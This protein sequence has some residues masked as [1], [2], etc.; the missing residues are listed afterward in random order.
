MR[1][2]DREKRKIPAALRFDAKFVSLTLYFAAARPTV[3]GVL[4]C[5][6]AA[7]EVKTTIDT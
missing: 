5:A 4:G 1:L 6:F 7:D 2:Q 3:F